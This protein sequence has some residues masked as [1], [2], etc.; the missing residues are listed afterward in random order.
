M[1]QPTREQLEEILQ[2]LVPALQPLQVILF[3]SAARGE[4]GP[5]SDIDLM[6]VMPE[7]TH[8]RH[9]M[10]EAHCLLTGLPFPVDVVVATPSDIERHAHSPAY[11]YATVLR[12]GRELYVS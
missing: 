8:R 2:R 3:G 6:V 11:I 12:E 1:R 7:G 10:E 5:D 4:M 9:T